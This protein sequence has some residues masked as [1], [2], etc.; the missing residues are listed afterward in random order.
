MP[1]TPTAQASMLLGLSCSVLLFLDSEARV[2]Q[3]QIAAEEKK[4]MQT[5]LEP[6]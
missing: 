1:N 2:R 6:Y 5:D 4:T 3:L